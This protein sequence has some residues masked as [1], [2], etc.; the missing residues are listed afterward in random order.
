MAE[1]VSLYHSDY[2]NDTR[3]EY[4]YFVNWHSLP[5]SSEGIPLMQFTRKEAILLSHDIYN[6]LT[7]LQREIQ[8]SDP[9]M[10]LGD[11]IQ[12]EAPNFDPDI[13]NVS[14]PTTDNISNNVLT[15]GTTLPTPK[16]TELETECYVAP[17]WFKSFHSESF[18][19]Q[20]RI[21]NNSL[22]CCMCSTSKI[23]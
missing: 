7:E 23:Y 6:K 5:S 22:S 20:F 17:I 21:W 4:V 12:I 2:I 14:A 1:F 18:L 9:H 3:S 15:Q 19:I 16:T 10:N 11:T 8:H 13:D